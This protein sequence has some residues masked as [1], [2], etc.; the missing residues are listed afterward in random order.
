MGNKSDAARSKDGARD[1]PARLGIHS[2][3]SPQRASEALYATARKNGGVARVLLAL[4][5]IV[6]V[7]VV[8]HAMIG[9]S[10]RDAN[11]ANAAGEKGAMIGGTVGGPIG[12]GVGY[13]IAAGGY[14]LLRKEKRKGEQ[15]FGKYVDEKVAHANTRGIL[16]GFQQTATIRRQQEDTDDIS[17]TG[18]DTTPALPSKTIADPGR[19]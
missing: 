4:A 9:C 15:I 5:L 8:I 13:A 3:Q 19:A 12:A 18:L 14:L 11:R 1:D 2:A 7:L 17:L 10:S 16:S 6:L